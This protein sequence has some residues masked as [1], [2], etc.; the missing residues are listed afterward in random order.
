MRF[1]PALLV[2]VE[3]QLTIVRGEV[4]LKSLAGLNERKS[5]EVRGKKGGWQ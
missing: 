1:T 5:W 3:K 4:P 2:A